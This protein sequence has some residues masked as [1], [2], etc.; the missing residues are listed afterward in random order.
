MELK[1]TLSESQM[2]EVAQGLTLEQL[3]DIIIHK[4][5]LTGEY[6]LGLKISQLKHEKD[7]E[8]VVIEAEG[9]EPDQEAREYEEELEYLKYNQE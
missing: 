6:E 4:A 3:L 8:T 9:C 7:K 2:K 5:F 1:L